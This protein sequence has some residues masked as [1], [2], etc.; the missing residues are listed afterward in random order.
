MRK[1]AFR[2]NRPDEEGQCEEC[3]KKAEYNQ[4]YG[5]VSIANIIADIEA[6]DTCIGTT[7][8]R[9]EYLVWEKGIGQILCMS[10]I[11]EKMGYHTSI[12]K[13]RNEKGG[14]FMRPPF[15]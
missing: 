2:I 12:P 5:V 9:A 14:I 13:I 7:R 15:N 11:Q 1:F 6:T 8:A 3:G 4:L 10:C